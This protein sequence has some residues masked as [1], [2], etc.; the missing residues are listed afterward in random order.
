MSVPG[1]GIF[2]FLP[3][4]QQVK[5]QKSPHPAWLFFSSDPK[6]PHTI[7]QPHNL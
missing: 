2:L 5:K 7:T 4:F 6:Q 3:T 1:E